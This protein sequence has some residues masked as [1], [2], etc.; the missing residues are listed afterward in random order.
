MKITNNLT[1]LVKGGSVIKR[2]TDIK[3][4]TYIKKCTYI[5]QSTYAAIC[6]IAFSILPA[7]ADTSSARFTLP[8]LGG[9]VGV[10]EIQNS[11]R[12]NTSEVANA[13]AGFYM[14]NN[15]S[16]ELWLAYLGQFDVKGRSD[17][18][19]NAVGG[20]TALAYRIDTG[21]QFALRPSVG[22]FYSRSKITFDGNEIGRD[23]GANLMLGLSGV[24]TI[25]NH[26]L[27]NINS[28]YFKDVSGSNI[29]MFS[30]GAGYQF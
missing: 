30:V 17:T 26:V 23:S 28:H 27:V 25:R 19:F 3:Q 20:G 9:N 15:L 10:S 7:H 8:Y 4:S 16:I 22:V 24:F 14:V 13:Y 5:K 6:A 12:Y 18:Y 11:D 21:K 1:A 29:L 2:S